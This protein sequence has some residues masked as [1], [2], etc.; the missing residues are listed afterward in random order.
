MIVFFLVRMIWK[1]FFIIP[2]ELDYPL[3]A[4]AHGRVHTHTRTDVEQDLLLGYFGI[5]NARDCGSWYY[6]LFTTI[7]S[8]KF[9]ISAIDTGYIKLGCNDVRLLSHRTASV[10][11]ISIGS[12][13]HFVDEAE[14]EV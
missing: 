8:P 9:Y 3:L 4:Q 1:T 2:C 12:V 13:S 7:C 6:L 14:K 5:P 11:V 10:S